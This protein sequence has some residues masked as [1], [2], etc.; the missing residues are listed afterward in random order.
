MVEPYPARDS[1]SVDRDAD[2]L[3]ENLLVVL[4]G[5]A[6]VGV[7]PADVG[8]PRSVRCTPKRSGCRGAYMVVAYR[9]EVPTCS[10]DSSPVPG[11]GS[12]QVVGESL[13]K[14]LPVSCVAP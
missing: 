12:G 3:I 1:N 2:Q 6:S 5:V 9:R 8:Q 14:C 7:K 13:S 11:Q 4:A 10:L